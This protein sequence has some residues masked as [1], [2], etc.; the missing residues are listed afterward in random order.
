[1]QKL[2]L[3]T[4]KFRLKSNDNK[5]FI[6][7]N[8]RKKYL[9]LTPEE[10][11]RQH[12]V[13]F[14]MEEKKYPA[15]LI[16]IEKQLVL[17]TLQKRTDIVIFSSDGTPNIIVECKAPK[18]KIAQDT[19]DQI[20]RYNLKLKANFLVVTNGLSHYFCKLDTKNEIYIFLKDIPDYK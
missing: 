9:V 18:I 14:L 17:N 13:R 10:W 5:T 11:V 16:A 1:M 19:F 3:P 4:Y 20:A 15:S 12:F 7:D 8:L 6:F 2:N